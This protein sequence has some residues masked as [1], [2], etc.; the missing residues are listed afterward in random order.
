MRKLL[1]GLGLLCLGMAAG[2]LLGWRLKKA[3]RTGLEEAR[4]R[5]DAINRKAFLDAKIVLGKPPIPLQE[6]G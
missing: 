2:F 3:K 1:M 5:V 4:H 6:R